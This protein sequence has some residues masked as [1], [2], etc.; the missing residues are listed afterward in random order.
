[1]SEIILILLGIGIASIPTGFF[2][3]HIIPDLPEQEEVE[4]PVYETKQHTVEP[5]ELDEEHFNALGSDVQQI[6]LKYL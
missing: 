4:K 3:K 2:V 6:L 5:A 1:M